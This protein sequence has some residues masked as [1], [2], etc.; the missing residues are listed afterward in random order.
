MADVGQNGASAAPRTLAWILDAA[1]GYFAG[2]HV[3]SPRATAEHLAARLLGCK[4][5]ALASS[6]GR[7]FSDAQLDA[8]RRGMKRVASGEPLQYVLGEW[9]FRSVTLKTD[10]R[11][12]IPRPETE[13]L[14]SLALAAPILKT[15]SAPRF[16]DYGTGT[17]CIALSI[18]AELR[19]AHVAA[20]DVS[21]DALALAA[22]NAARLGLADRVRF[23]NTS[24]IDLA[25][26]FEPASIDVIVSNPPYIPSAAVDA[27]DAKVLAH[28]PR[29]ALDGGADGMDVI[30][31]LCED[32]SMLLASGGMM[33]LEIDAESNQAEKLSPLLESYGFADIV[34]SRDV[35]GAERFISATLPEGL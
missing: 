27:L 6:L 13:E 9:D 26:V 22:E 4:R 32:A 30:R 10:R 25:D 15:L 35:S 24:E 18:A 21:A 16:L 20:V 1:T 8:M 28:E 5:S 19:A 23:L 14:V 3:D 11:A 31:T 12:L 17:G 7:A 2:L 29:L 33:F 34:V